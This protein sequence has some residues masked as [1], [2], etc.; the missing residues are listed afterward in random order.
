[1]KVDFK[2][3]SLPIIHPAHPF[4]FTGDNMLGIFTTEAT[5]RYIYGTRFITW[6]GKVYKYSLSGAACYTHRLN[7]FWNTIS[8]DVNGIDYSLLTNAQSAGDREITLTNGTTAVAEDYL[9]GGII[10]IVPTETT[11]DREVMTRGIIGNDV[12]AAAAECK[13]YLDV[14]LETAVTA[15]NYA[16]VMPSNYSNIRYSASVNGTRSFAGLAATAVTAAALNFWCQTYG[17]CNMA[18]QS[19][20]VGK[21]AYYRMVYGRHDGSGDTQDQTVESGGTVVSDQIVGFGMDNNGDAN[22]T[23]NMMLTISV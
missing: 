15:S 16:Y 7:A 6:D 12:A 4:D 3:P 1:M 17:P 9:A 23:T 11:T 2:L 5:Q 21:T 20:R 13:M 18:Y 10:I 22:G 14:P 8:S 19:A